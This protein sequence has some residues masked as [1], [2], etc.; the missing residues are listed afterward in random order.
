M[1]DLFH[2]NIN[3]NIIKLWTFIRKVYIPNKNL[4]GSNNIH[5]IYFTCV[6]MI[7]YTYIIHTL[8]TCTYVPV[9]I[10]LFPFGKCDE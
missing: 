3:N 10:L 8:C 6:Q 7:I 9:L 1:F 2:N 5:K 4:V